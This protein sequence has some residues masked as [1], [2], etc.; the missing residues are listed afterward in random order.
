MVTTVQAPFEDKEAA[1]LRRGKG[2]KES[3]HDYLLRKVVGDDWAEKLAKG[4]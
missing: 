2:E 3:W 1:L 4:E